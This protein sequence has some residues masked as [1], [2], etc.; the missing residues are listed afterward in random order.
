MSYRAIAAALALREVSTGER[1]V[2]FS[3]AS[4]ANSDQ[5]AWPSDE[6]AAA[7]SGLRRSRYLAARRSLAE[8]GLI[9]IEQPGRGRG[10]STLVTLLYAEHGSGHDGRDQR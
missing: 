1:L 10:K 9:Q 3:L 2:V 8:R 5:Q 6:V 7:R 4:Y